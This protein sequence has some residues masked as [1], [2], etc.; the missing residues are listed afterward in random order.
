MPA[1]PDLAHY[2]RERPQSDTVRRWQAQ[3]ARYLSSQGALGPF[4]VDHDLVRFDPETGEQI[5]LAT[6][7]HSQETGESQWL[8]TKTG[9]RILEQK[10]NEVADGQCGKPV[11]GPFGSFAGFQSSIKYDATANIRLTTPAQR[12]PAS[13]Q[14]ASLGR[15]DDAPTQLVHD[16]MFFD[17]E[18]LLDYGV[19]L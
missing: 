8:N 5:Y 3:K 19:S 10:L 17:E 2:S 18:D 4:E 6:R 9:A 13:S 14:L 7:A 16:P 15:E 12:V 1:T 11:A